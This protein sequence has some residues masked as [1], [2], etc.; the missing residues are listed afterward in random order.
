MELDFVKLRDIKPA[1]SGYIRES[2]IMLKL[3]PFPDEKV[4]HDIRV[5]MKKSRS[6]MKLVESQV[7]AEG[8]TRDYYTF[9]EVG[10]IM[11]SWRET[12]VHRKTLKELKKNHAKLFSMADDE[13][14]E[15][16]MKK[17]DLTE[18]DQAGIMNDLE[19]INELLNKAGY[20]LRFQSMDNFDPK[21]LIR[22]LDNTYNNVVE[23]YLVCRN[24]PKPANLHLFRKRAKDF[25]Y[26]LWFF[27]PLNPTIV[28][29]LEKKLD[30]LTQS[31]GKYNDLAQ[32]VN[33]I[34]YKYSV[35]GNSPALDELIIIIREEQ[36]RYLSKVWS[37]AYKVFCPGQKLVNVLG[38][39]ILMI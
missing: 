17:P 37:V 36:D 14:L 26:Q 8:Y 4:V 7:D 20:R 35:S 27:R 18:G 13:K 28:K 24:N 23:K 12:S 39:R 32:L 29:A 33:T 11:A 16:L 5:L 21:V 19:N 34:G 6:V 30:T 31:L 1:L 9:R 2:Q 15:A 10:R 38:F 22:M 25:L 3:S